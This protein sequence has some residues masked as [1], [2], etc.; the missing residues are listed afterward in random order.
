[1]A[2]KQKIVNETVET[3]SGGRGLRVLVVLA[4]LVAGAYFGGPALI[5][6]LQSYAPATAVP[7]DLSLGTWVVLGVL[8]LFLAWCFSGSKGG[9]R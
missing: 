6:Y 8:G 4:A 5:A 9:R 3:T 2:R 7:G 1:M